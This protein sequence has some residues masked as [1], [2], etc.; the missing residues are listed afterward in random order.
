MAFPKQPDETVHHSPKV[1]TLLFKIIHRIHFRFLVLTYKTLRQIQPFLTAISPALVSSGP[2][3]PC[4]TCIY[5]DVIHIAFT[6]TSFTGKN[7]INF[8]SSPVYLENT[9]SF[10]KFGSKIIFSKMISLSCPG[11]G[12]NAVLKKLKLYCIHTSVIVAMTY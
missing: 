10:P 4:Y 7:P 9:Y 11:R 3:A 8:A 1:F 5:L 2:Q 12:C 6:F